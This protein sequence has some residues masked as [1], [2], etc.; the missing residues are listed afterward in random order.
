ML[1]HSVHRKT[2]GGQT[3]RNNTNIHR[4]KYMKKSVSFKKETTAK[5]NVGSVKGKAIAAGKIAKGKK[6][7]Y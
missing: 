7:K 4:R 1:A 3:P 6:A 2:F 5:R